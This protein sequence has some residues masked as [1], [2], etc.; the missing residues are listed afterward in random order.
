M[1]NQLNRNKISPIENK[2]HQFKAGVDYVLEEEKYHAPHTV[3]E[4][5]HGTMDI[6]GYTFRNYKII[7][8]ELRKNL[9][10]MLTKKVAILMSFD[11]KGNGTV[12]EHFSYNDVP[13]NYY[14]QTD[15]EFGYQIVLQDERENEPAQLSI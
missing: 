11:F 1:A 7:S 13:N 9:R 10:K 8:P 14:C 5:K 3:G 4:K 2:I 12:N 6:R 15:D